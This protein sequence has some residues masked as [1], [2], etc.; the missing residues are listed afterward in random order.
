[1][2]NKKKDI[3]SS[4]FYY[5]DDNLKN[6]NNPKQGGSKLH[7]EISFGANKRPMTSINNCIS[8]RITKNNKIHT[9]LNNKS[10]NMVN[11]NNYVDKGINNNKIEITHSNLD[12]M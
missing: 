5:K 4:D 7:N 12:L 11:N 8:V 6:D 10:I 2:I 9:S 1:M 3:C